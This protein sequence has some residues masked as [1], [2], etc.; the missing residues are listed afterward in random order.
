[1]SFRELT[2]W[3][4]GLIILG[5]YGNFLLHAPEHTDP[6]A[7]SAA[8]IRVVIAMVLVEVIVM[9]VLAAVH[10]RSDQRA[11]ERDTAIAAK[12]YRNSYF[13]MATGVFFAIVYTIGPDLTRLFETPGLPHDIAMMHLLLLAFVL[14]ELVNFGSR[15]LYYRTGV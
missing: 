4:S 10:A 15:I 5:F 7:T 13:V 8:L 3:A 1:M 12:S 11:D 14:A 9:I 6:E 2:A